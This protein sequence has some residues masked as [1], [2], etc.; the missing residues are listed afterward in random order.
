MLLGLPEDP[1]KTEFV[2]NLL[3]K[4]K[5]GKVSWN[6][7]GNAYT[8]AIPN[9]I[10]VNFVT[11]PT[12]FGTGPSWQLFTVRD[13]EGNELIQVHAPDFVSIIS[14]TATG[15]L[16]QATNQLFTAVS[17]ISGDELERAIESLK[18]L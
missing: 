17:G 3:A 8:A 18:K 11:G 10:V 4:T 7:K 14:N 6:K 16:L 12:L 9:G 13:R 5:V 1:R 15:A 2:I